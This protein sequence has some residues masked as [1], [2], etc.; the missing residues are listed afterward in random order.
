[1]SKTVLITGTSNGFGNDVAKTLA[2]AKHRVFATMRDSNGRN[3]EAAQEQED[4]KALEAM[5]L[6]ALDR[7]KG[8][9]D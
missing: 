8:L 1:M 4:A 9:T 2:A 7:L 6:T 3:R 5:R